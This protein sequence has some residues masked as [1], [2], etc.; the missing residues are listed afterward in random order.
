MAGPGSATADRAAT[1]TRPP[2]LETAREEDG[3]HCVR[4][5]RLNEPVR[6]AVPPGTGRRGRA[7]RGLPRPEPGA[8]ERRTRCRAAAPPCLKN[9][10]TRQRD[11]DLVGTPAL[12]GVWRH[13]PGGL[14]RESG[15]SQ[16]GDNCTFTCSFLVV[17]RGKTDHHH[18][19]RCC[20]CR[21]PSAAVRPLSQKD[22]S[23]R[24][25]QRAN[26]VRLRATP[27]DSRRQSPQVNG[28]SGHVQRRRNT[29][30]IWFASRRPGVRVPLA[31]QIR[32]QM[33][34]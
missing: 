26:G 8:G 1:L 13:L 11:V 31:P 22:P 32:G 20:E 6:S 14:V 9:G 19:R 4:P 5:A 18:L 28:P 15:K 3:C 29:Q 7:G 33:R 21:T 27:T 2:R 12:S 17:A 24:A 25:K 30:K 10:T 16:S 23:K 34:S